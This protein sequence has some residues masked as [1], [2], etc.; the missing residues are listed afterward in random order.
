MKKIVIAFLA[1]ISLNIFAG[2]SAVTVT[3]EPSQIVVN[4][5]ATM[6]VRVANANN[7]NRVD[8]P[9]ISGLKFYAGEE[10]HST[11]WYNGKESSYIQ[12]TYY[13]KPT[14]S[15][16]FV[17]S[18]IEVMA[19]GKIYTPKSV[20]LNVVSNPT[21]ASKGTSVDDKP[22]NLAFI[23]VYLQST[24]VYVG[25]YIPVK[26]EG[27]FRGDYR[28]QLTKVPYFVGTAFRINKLSDTP[29]QR[30]V[31][32][33]GKRYTVVSW[34]AG[35]SPLKPGNFN[36]KAKLGARVRVP[37][38]RRRRHSL[39][40]SFFDDPFSNYIDKDIE[41]ESTSK[42]VEV[43][44]LPMN[45]KPADFSGAIGQF[46]LTAKTDTDTIAEGDPITIKLNI[47]GKGNFSRIKLPQISDTKNWRVYKAK[48]LFKAKDVI[49]YWGSKS[50][51]LP[52]IPEKLN[53]N[54]IPKFSFSY[55]DPF[56]EKYTTVSTPQIPVKVSKSS[57]N[58]STHSTIAQFENELK[59]QD[60]KGQNSLKT[61]LPPVSVELNS[62]N[63]G[64]LLVQQLWF[65]VFNILLVIGIFLLLLIKKAKKRFT[66]SDEEKLRKEKLTQI[67]C[68]LQEAKSSIGKSLEFYKAIN[69]AIKEYVA[70]KLSMESSAVTLLEV[71][72]LFADQ[73][74]AR[75]F[76]KLELIKFMGEE[77][78]EA[79]M[80]LA[81]E[82]VRKKIMEG[83]E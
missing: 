46:K 6:Q 80:K 12:K 82:L 41:V 62:K 29:N 83:G 57:N 55:F 22:E 74:I 45:G 58:D 21:V 42:S 49:N 61:V 72:K 33:K 44:Q 48:P 16:K 14:K 75:V 27:Y 8:L 28:I 35:I 63:E 69:S 7:I 56:K 5:I 24:K 39:L 67:E 32:Y 13:V 2:Q 30:Q 79:Q 40:D 52:I 81:Y 65:K 43:K 26:I 50:F 25:Q 34:Y 76:E 23:K 66:I 4:K 78:P 38:T 36:L 3:I 18:G 9:T 77:V 60:D 20:T 51:E 70:I 10:L 47:S 17:I 31:S 37:V 68:Y 59:Q 71:E 64:V 53:D 19:D 1:I 15:G 73:E 11:N 54:F